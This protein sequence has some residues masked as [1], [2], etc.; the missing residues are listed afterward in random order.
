MFPTCAK[1]TILNRENEDQA[2]L[3]RHEEQKRIYHAE[4]VQQIEQNLKKKEEDQRR[5]QE[6]KMKE[7]QEID[8]QM[9]KEKAD[10]K[11]KTKTQQHHISGIEELQKID[12]EKPKGVTNHKTETDS[13][14][15]FVNQNVGLKTDKSQLEAKDKNRSPRKTETKAT[16]GANQLGSFNEDSLALQMEY[17]RK[18]SHKGNF[19]SQI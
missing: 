7:K 9:R 15:L 17:L 10:L 4:L 16:S 6:Q 14:D 18:F 2:Q 8:E 13:L 1:R 11:M 3:T 12:A 19:V 5:I